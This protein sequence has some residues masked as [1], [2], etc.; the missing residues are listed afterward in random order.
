MGAGVDEA[1]ADL[2]GL[3]GGDPAGDPEDDAPAGELRGVHLPPLTD[4]SPT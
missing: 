4:K 2:D 1:T 3:V